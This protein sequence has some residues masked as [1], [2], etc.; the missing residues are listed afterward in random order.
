MQ[1]PIP[2]LLHACSTTNRFLM[3]FFTHVSIH[4][5]RYLD[6]WGPKMF[7]NK[8]TK[9]REGERGNSENVSLPLSAGA[10]NTVHHNLACDGYIH[11]L[12]C[13]SKIFRHGN[14]NTLVSAYSSAI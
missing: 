4:R 5:K 6:R 13:P 11:L 3:S 12:L 7:E 8:E 14:K 2:P 1:G 9:M 10:Y